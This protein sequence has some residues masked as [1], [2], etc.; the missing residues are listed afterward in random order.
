MKKLFDLNASFNLLLLV[1]RPDSGAHE[2]VGRA[3]EKRMEYPRGV[4]GDGTPTDAECC[5]WYYYC[6]SRAV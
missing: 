2:S 3:C 6:F 4:K 1:E 5:G